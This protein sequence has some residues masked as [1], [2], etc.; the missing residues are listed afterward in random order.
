MATPKFRGLAKAMALLEHNLEDGAGKLMEK[1]ESVGSRGETALAD[2]HTK[3]DGIAG[4]VAEVEDFVAAI[5]GS[6]GAPDQPSIT[7]L[8]TNRWR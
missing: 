4:R 2:G 3:V 5:E 7:P 6:N 1:I 8:E